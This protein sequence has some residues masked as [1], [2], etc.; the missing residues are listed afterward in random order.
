MRGSDIVLPSDPRG[1]YLE[2]YAGEALSP[3][4]IVNIKRGVKL[5]DGN[6]FTWEAYDGAGGV[7]SSTGSGSDGNG[8][9]AVVNIDF[10]QGKSATDAYASGDR[11]F[12]YVPYAGEMINIMVDSSVGSI[13]IGDTLKPK[14][15]DG[16][17]QE[18][19]SSDS[20]IPFQSAEEDGSI[21]S[22]TLIACI[23]TGK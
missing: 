21:S 16:T 18:A 2:G 8:L 4:Q 13:E 14:N 17:L 19:S 23:A 12:L 7:G 10:L 9:L 11:V 20:Y 22:D 6:A 15:G 3:G 1:M 5:R